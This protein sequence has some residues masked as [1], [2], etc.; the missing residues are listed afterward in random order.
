M[1]LS[2]LSM[3]NLERRIWTMA[4]LGQLQALVQMSQCI[5]TIVLVMWRRIV[6]F[7]GVLMVEIGRFWALY[8]SVCSLPLWNS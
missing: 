4:D 3:G 8:T 7:L 2:F 1:L 6:P 5:H